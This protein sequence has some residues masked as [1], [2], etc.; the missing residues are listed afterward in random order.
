MADTKV[1]GLAAVAA[2]LGSHEY[3]V[4]EAGTS[5][6]IT[7]TQIIAA[8]AQ[9]TLPSG[10]AQVTANQTGISAE[11]DLTSL[12]VTVTPG[13]SRRIRITAWARIAQNTAGATPA[14]SI[15]EGA[16]VLTAANATLVI[17]A[18]TN[19]TAIVILTP[20]AVAHTY[21]LTLQTGAGTVD[22]LASATNPA[23]VLAEDIGV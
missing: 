23:F 8:V 6:K 3:P 13:T 7:G 22:L 12:T 9:G 17:A 19:L 15:K 21:K 5:K 10:Y 1:S 20:T 14:L 4:N 11:T 2:F 18:Q 16:T